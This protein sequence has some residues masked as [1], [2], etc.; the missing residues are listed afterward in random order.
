[1]SSKVYVQFGS[2]TEAVPGWV[3][4]DASP[5]LV[6]QRFPILG[7]L[8]RSKLNC[9]F[10]DQIQYG[11]IVK[12]LPI[13]NESVDGLFCSHVLE[14]LTY[15]DFNIALANSF[16]YL[17]WGGVF[18]I[19]VPDLEWCI[20][21]YIRSKQSSDPMQ[22][23]RASIDFMNENGTNLGLKESR[24]TLRRRLMDAFRGSGHR[25]MWDYDSLS[26]AL[27]DYGFVDIRRFAQ[28]HSEDEMFLRPER[29][30]QFGNKQNPY[31]L[32]VECRKPARP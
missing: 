30:H 27:A 28:G 19:I 29:D 4:F 15:S 26:S 14:H 32:A 18:R 25:W 6:I 31:G 2:G 9:L 3:S 8:F 21:S 10:D 17:K 1:M 20:K 11:D 16:R 13:S 5:T 12:G 24:L 7:Q 22:V 23:V